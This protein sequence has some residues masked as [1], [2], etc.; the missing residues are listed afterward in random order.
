VVSTYIACLESKQ[1]S[2]S[3]YWNSPE[4]SQHAL[5][6]QKL[7]LAARF[8]CQGSSLCSDERKHRGLDS[9]DGY[10]RGALQEEHLFFVRHSPPRKT[11]KR[12]K[13]KEQTMK[14]ERI[15]L[16]YQQGSS[17][18]VYHLELE[19]VGD[20]WSVNAQWGRRGSALQSDSKANG[21]TYEEGKRVFDR[22]VR[23]KTGKGYRVVQTNGAA[24]PAIAVGMPTKEFSGHAP[25]LLTPIE[26]RE[27]LDF[28]PNLSWWF[29]QKFDGRRLAVQ[30]T[31]GKYSGI[32]KLGQII[33][34]D[35]QLA[36]SL[37]NV[38]ADS[39]LVDGEITNSK[40][41]MWDILTLNGDDLRN[42][43]YEARYVHL[44]RLFQ[45][46]DDVLCVAETAM[47]P[48]AKRNLVA[49]MHES[50]A[51]GFV[52]KN[53]NAV[54]AGGRSGQHFKCKFVA[55]ASFIVGPKPDKKAADG[56]RSIAVYLLDGNRE[57]FMGTVGV[58]E[59]YRFPKDGQ[60]V[61]VRY[62]Y[63]HPGPDGKLIQAKYFGH[64]RD[65]IERT[66]CLVGQLQL[67]ADEGELG[68]S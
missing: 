50:R 40:F 63:C 5:P 64:V 59:R 9:A 60:V 31:N 4:F 29:Q 61:E 23:E 52:C 36:A 46:V 55:S 25:E 11:Q 57:R 12:T 35:A 6:A 38:R 43:P 44:T 56:H 33:S 58:P 49:R 47:T 28:V 67:K 27:A 15:D 65:D 16:Y 34:I 20:K 30:K 7:R 21:V 18:K 2:R 3:R 8:F 53:R 39:F 42:H 13:Q 1:K 26:E 45:G 51:E 32:N 17:D 48:K 19:G 37:D 14:V 22:V 41:Y 68:E 62:L 66:E 10:A 24:S 54:Y